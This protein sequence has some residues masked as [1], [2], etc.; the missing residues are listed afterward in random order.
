MLIDALRITT[1]AQD[2]IGLKWS[3][4]FP[5]DPLPRHTNLV[6]TFAFFV[7]VNIIAQVRKEGHNDTDNTLFPQL[8][9]LLFLMGST[10]DKTNIY[11]ISH[12]IFHQVLRSD[13]PNVR[14][15]R[16]GLS[17]LV[18]LYLIGEENL[19]EKLK[20]RGFPSLFGSM[21]KSLLSSAE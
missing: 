14:K 5:G 3:P 12:L 4:F 21:L 8:V 13:L 2:A 9:H 10:E 15:W 20:Q 19:D 17:D 1:D 18:F 7:T 16:Q 6:V 11:T